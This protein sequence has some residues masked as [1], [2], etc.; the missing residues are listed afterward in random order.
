M[1]YHQLHIYRVW[2]YLDNYISNTLLFKKKNQLTLF[3]EV[4][5]V[6]STIA[7]NFKRQT[8]DTD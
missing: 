7:Q 8:Y 5:R 4:N 2:E 1:N 3:A 6:N